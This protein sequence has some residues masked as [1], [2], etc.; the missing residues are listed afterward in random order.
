MRK[1]GFTLIELLV[2]IAI[3][4][5][6][7]SLLLPAL[8]KAKGKGQQTVCSSNLRQMGIAMNMYVG[9]YNK[10]P[11]HYMFASAPHPH[12]GSIVWPGR[13]FPYA[14]KN[15]NLFF[16][17]S[18][19]P[20]Y[21]WTTNSPRPN[22]KMPFNILPGNPGTGFSYGYNDWGVR[23]F[24]NGESGFSLGLGGDIGINRSFGEVPEWAV[25]V[26]TDMIAITD[27]QS[28][29][30]WDTAVDPTDPGTFANPAA[31]WPSRRH[32]LGSNVL[33][34]DGHV[35][36]GKQMDLVARK[37]EMRRRWN[38]DNQPHQEYW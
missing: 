38:N 4:A 22:M 25:K 32:N 1:T 10:F 19:K 18:N 6:L 30:N 23:E 20:I 9:D 31:E 37:P 28:D 17:P 2:V 15:R 12:A 16:C 35:E 7:A 34:V 14:G 26:P 3:I 5:I 21:Q 13:L 36:F 33:F 8:S 24:V 27:S 29:N 11:G